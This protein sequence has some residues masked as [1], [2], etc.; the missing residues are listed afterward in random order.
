[1]RICVS[2]ESFEMKFALSCDRYPQGTSVGAKG[3]QRSKAKPWA[4]RSTSVRDVRARVREP[5]GP[6][7][8]SLI[9]VL[10]VWEDLFEPAAGEAD[11]SG[12]LFDSQMRAVIGI[13]ADFLGAHTQG[14][15]ELLKLSAF[16]FPV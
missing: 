2:S 12:V 1:M 8:G 14:L 7:V 15:Q 3:L 13:I 9:F 16:R 10:F 4:E 6:V 11:V 5:D